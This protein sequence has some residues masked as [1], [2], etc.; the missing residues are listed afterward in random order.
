MAWH[1]EAERLDGAGNGELIASE[2]P[3]QNVSI[4]QTLSGPDSM[5]AT[6]S[7]AIGRL[8]DDDGLPLLSGDWSTAI[9]AIE[10]TE[11]AA[12]VILDQPRFNGPNFGLEGGGFAGYAYGMPYTA[13]NFWVK[14][15]YADA[16]RQIWTHLQ[17]Q[18]GGNLGLEVDAETMTG[19]TIGTELKQGE[20]DTINGPLTFEDGPWRLAW[21]QT[22]DLGAEM[23]KL[24]QQAP[25]D[26][27]ERHQYTNDGSHIRHFIDLGYP[28]IGRVINDLRFVI[29]EN[30]AIPEIADHGEIYANEWLQLGAGEGSAMVR[31]SSSAPRRGLRRVR[32]G[33]DK[34]L[35]TVASANSS[36]SL[37]LR[38]AANI[39]DVTSLTLFDHPNA[40]SGSVRVGDELL[41]E[42]RVD[43]T[44][45]SMWVRVTSRTIT[46]GN[47]ASVQ[48]N[49]TRTD[50]MAG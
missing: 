15:D 40:P 13:S 37:N 12:G 33:T 43:W 1:Y 31:G 19:K 42:G 32:V 38:K 28:K 49:V 3:L 26:W 14:I 25:M 11:I 5:S 6:V 50:R 39:R 35:K 8:K 47:L 41:L 48:L 17:S 10:D 20:F 9:Y 24:V 23:D 44:E 4:T 45:I 27:R 7:P 2:L 22:S 30:V 21:Y 36:A 29:G 16:F 34:T 18:P 46:P